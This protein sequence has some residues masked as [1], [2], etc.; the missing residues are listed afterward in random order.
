MSPTPQPLQWLALGGG[1]YARFSTSGP[2]VVFGTC[3]RRARGNGQLAIIGDKNLAALLEAMQTVCG[4]ATAAASIFR[5]LPVNQSLAVNFEPGKKPS[6]DA[7]DIISISPCGDNDRTFS[8]IGHSSIEAL[9]QFLVANLE[10]L[11]GQ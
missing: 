4:D 9:I 1:A 11:R 5:L 3:G 7:L 8:I 6:G 10:A 2:L